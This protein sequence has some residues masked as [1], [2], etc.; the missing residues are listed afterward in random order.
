MTDAELFNRV[1]SIDLTLEEIT[2]IMADLALSNNVKLFSKFTK[3]IE[4]DAA[5]AAIQEKSKP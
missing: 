2:E 3:A 1:I 5:L 4:T